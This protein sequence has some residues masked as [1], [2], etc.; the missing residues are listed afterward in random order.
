MLYFGPETIMPLA[1]ALAVVAGVVLMFWRRTV[2]FV[3]VVFAHLA[4]LVGHRRGP[5]GPTRGGGAAR[6]EEPTSTTGREV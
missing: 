5:T 3:R 1:S 4:S 2:G 6:S